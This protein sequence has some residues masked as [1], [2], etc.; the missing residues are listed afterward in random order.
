MS[1]KVVEWCRATCFGLPVGPWRFGRGA[2]RRDLMAEGLGSY[3]ED[4][5]FYITVPG[6]LDVRQEWVTFEEAQ[7]LALSVK[8]R[9]AAENLKRRSVAYDNRGVRWVRRTRDK[10]SRIALELLE[11]SF[12]VS[13]HDDI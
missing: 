8:R 5:I 13:V 12:T 10:S 6:G 4:G 11:G 2:A 9:H 7:E 3:D 1:R